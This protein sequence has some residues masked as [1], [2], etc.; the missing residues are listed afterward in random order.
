MVSLRIAEDGAKLATVVEQLQAEQKG[1]AFERFEINGLPAANTLVSGRGRIVDLTLIEYGRK[2]Y[3]VTGQA[4]GDDAAQFVKSFNLT[5]RSFRA[6]SSGERRSLEESRLRV[7]AARAGET[8]TTIAERTGSTWSPE[9]L[10]VANGIDVDT[11]LKGGQ[12]VKV[13]KPQSYTP[14]KR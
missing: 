14:R 3:A 2:V 8:S 6:L 4:A 11:H 1:L 7:R 12:L 10:A 9:A 5:A 13:A